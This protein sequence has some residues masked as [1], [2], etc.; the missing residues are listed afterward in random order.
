MRNKSWNL[1]Y[2][3]HTES[4]GLNR[5]ENG[6]YQLNNSYWD[7]EGYYKADRSF[8]RKNQNYYEILDAIDNLRNICK[9]IEC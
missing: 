7:K 8:T 5:Q 6:M 4:I 2:P 9:V 3:D 1:V